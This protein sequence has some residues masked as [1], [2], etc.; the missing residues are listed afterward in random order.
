MRRQ[1]A[2]PLKKD[3]GIFLPV[4]LRQPPRSIVV[5]AGVFSNT[6]MSPGEHTRKHRRRTGL[7]KK[8]AG[9]FLPVML[10]Q[11]P[12]SIVVTAGVFSNTLMSPGGRFA[13]ASSADWSQ[14]KFREC[15]Y[16]LFQYY[17]H[18]IPQATCN[19]PRQQ[20][21]LWNIRGSIVSGLI[22]KRRVRECSYRCY[23][24]N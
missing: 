19:W 9:M 14:R 21:H 12:R 13:E 8:G 1:R 11:Q 10:R 2:G 17:M 3:A 6:L 23:W 16:R 24:R 22:R 15:S 18:E 4:M 5:T 20:C 7:R